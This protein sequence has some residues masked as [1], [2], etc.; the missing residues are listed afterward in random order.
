MRNTTKC[1]FQ[2]ELILGFFLEHISRPTL[3]YPTQ[4]CPALLPTSTYTCPALLP[5]WLATYVQH[6]TALDQIRKDPLLK[7]NDSDSFGRIKQLLSVVLKA[8][9]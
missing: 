8:P 9:E 3:P 2:S 5:T 1:V 7:Q 4:P 6:Q